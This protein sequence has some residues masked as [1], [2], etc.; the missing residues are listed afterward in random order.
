VLTI[1]VNAKLRWVS[2]RGCD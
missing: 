1:I 2:A